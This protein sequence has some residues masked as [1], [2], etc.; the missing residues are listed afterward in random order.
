[1]SARNVSKAEGK[2]KALSRREFLRSLGLGV[3]GGLLAYPLAGGLWSLPACA[4]GPASRIIVARDPSLL[5]VSGAA[6]SAKATALLDKAVASFVGTNEAPAAWSRLFS[7]DDTVAIM[8]N[9]CHSR[10][11]GPT[12]LDLLNHVIKKLTAAGVRGANIY[13]TERDDDQLA[14]NGN[15]TARTVPAPG[16]HFYAHNWKDFGTTQYKMG[17]GRVRI[18]RIYE[19]PVTAI[20]R[21][22]LFRKHMNFK[23]TGAM[24]MIMGHHS[25]PRGAHPG[26][27]RKRRGKKGGKSSVDKNAFLAD[28]NNIAPFKTKTR[29]VIVEGVG[30]LGFD[31][32][33]VG[34]DPV[35]ID[36]RL[37]SLVR[38]QRLSSGIAPMPYFQAG[39][40]MGLGTLDP[41]KTE[42]IAVRP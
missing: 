37:W 4:A 34:K 29:L 11:E 9:G 21:M 36:A 32:L 7:A 12:R 40:Q 28:L 30:R 17:S 25:N 24:K 16:V 33:L 39:E 35:T 2:G 3:G 5:G 22:P 38:N 6:Q 18:S 41:T 8:V 23:F 14:V 1:M 31:G 19:T 10:A 15:F 20:I 13:L 42:V 26:R 27:A